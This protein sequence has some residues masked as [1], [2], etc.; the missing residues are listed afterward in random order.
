MSHKRLLFAFLL[1]LIVVG[2]AIP[3]YLRGKVNTAVFSD[4][5][6][7]RIFTMV[8]PDSPTLRDRRIG[9]LIIGHLEKQGYRASSSEEQANTAV[10]YKFSIGPG[11][12][13]VSSR[14]NKSTGKT[15]VSSFTSYPRFFQLTIVDLKETRATGKPVLIWQGEVYS[16][17]S[18]TN[19]AKLSEHFLE[20]LFENFGKTVDEKSFHRVVA[21]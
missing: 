1:V 13:S 17:G 6:G 20:I 21:R 5:P 3:A 18:S 19:T 12:V 8:L 16:E 7:K 15:S 9:H 4:P 14:F 11:E 10:L 2:C